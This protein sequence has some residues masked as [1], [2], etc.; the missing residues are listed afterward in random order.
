ME[1][2]LIVGGGIAGLQAAI[3][4]GRYGHRVLVIDGGWG[5]SVWCHAYHNLLGWPD[6]VSGPYLRAIGRAQAERFGVRFTEDW[7]ERAERIHPEGFRLTGAG[8]KTYAGRRLLIAT[9]VSDHLPDVAGLMPRLG[10]SV[11]ICPDCDGY[12][13]RGK[14]TVVL[15]RGDAGA[16]MALA[17]YA[18]TPHLVFLD[19]AAD[20]VA[21]HLAEALSER[22]I[23][24]VTGRAVAL[25]GPGDR[26]EGV[27][28]ADGRVMEAE[29]AFIAFGGNRVHA[30]IAV[31]LGVQVHDNH[32]IP[33][34]PRTRATNVPG[35]WAAGD[36]A[37]HSEQVSIAMGDGAQAAIWI[38]KSLTGAGKA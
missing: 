14:R 25:E 34:H 22:G 26:L 9:G 13:V 33:V 7:I 8:G 19:H 4:L 12:E 16:G 11:Y 20:P 6:G 23:R 36:V 29:G 2:C 17:L 24:R 30:E 38:H 3:Q 31:Q 32:H 1:D 37:A 27:R 21:Q 35:V 5:R 10:I 18:F 28:L 15:G